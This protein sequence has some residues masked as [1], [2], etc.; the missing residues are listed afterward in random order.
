MAQLRERLVEQYAP[1]VEQ[2]VKE[3]GDLDVTGIPAPH[4]PIVGKNYEM[5][6]YRIAFIGI[7]T[8]GWAD[9][10]EFIK[11]AKSDSFK[12]VT[13]MEDTINN[14][15]HLGWAA[16]YHATFWG[17]V[18]KFISKFYKV[19]FE[20]LV[21]NLKYP[22]LLCSFLYGNTNAIERYQVTA[23]NNGVKYCTWEFVK[24]ASVCFDSINNIVKSAAPRLVFVL[25]TGVEDDYLSN[26]DAVRLWGVP[27]GNKKSVMRIPVDSDRKICYYYLRDDNTHIISL[28]HPRWMGTYSGYGI[29]SYVDIVIDLISKYS[30]WER[31]PEDYTCWKGASGDLDKASISYK[32]VLIADLAASLMK[33]NLVMSG[34][35]LQILFN[36]N[37]VLTKNGSPYSE[38]GGRGIHN[39][40]S[41]VWKYYYNNKDFQT[42]YNITRAFVNQNG[43]YAWE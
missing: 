13:Y 4:I 21:D 37:G 18:F 11:V 25:N 8:L 33:N 26:D 6:K 12:A 42:A 38:D 15:E 24:R 9:I 20:D 14:L 23:E 16:N 41:Q 1:L 43:E 36:M 28:P 3:I 5:A 32:R 34:K 22:E 35:E 27:I 10:N 2:F 39:L 7:E 29:D 40:I 31:L 17:F 19:G 30:I